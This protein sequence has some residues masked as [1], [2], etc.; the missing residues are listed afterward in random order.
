MMWLMGA[1]LCS[2]PRGSPARP[3]PRPPARR[4]PP[5]ASAPACGSAACRRRPSLST[6]YRAAAGSGSAIAAPGIPA[7]RWLRRGELQFRRLGTR[8]FR[9]CISISMPHVILK[10]TAILRAAMLPQQERSP[11]FC[12]AAPRAVLR[13]PRI[14]DD[15]HGG[16][17]VQK[18]TCRRVC[19]GICVFALC[20]SGPAQP[21]HAFA[22]FAED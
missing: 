17:G 3:A 2:E 9:W 19:F 1:G 13:A 7:G 10:L 12:A 14:D 22:V 16:Y 6:V 11:C 5:P 4:P 21:W 8:R 18:N 15:E 20:S